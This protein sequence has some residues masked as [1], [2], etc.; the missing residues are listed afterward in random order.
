MQV[1][2]KNWLVSQGFKEYA[3]SGARSTALDYMGRVARVCAFEKLTWNQLSETIDNV[4][5]QYEHVGDKSIIGKKSHESVVNALR[6]FKT[7]AKIN[8]TLTLKV[9]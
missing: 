4:L 1:E 7:F 2:F 6:H 8:K 5:P 9:Q 3:D